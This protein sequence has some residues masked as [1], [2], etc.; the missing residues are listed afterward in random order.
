MLNDRSLIN[1]GLALCGG[2]TV[3]SGL[4][5]L[6][7]YESDLIKG[8][9]EVASLFLAAFA[10]LHLRL[11]WRAFG[12]TLGSAPGIRLIMIILAA[13]TSA[14]LVSGSFYGGKTLETLLQQCKPCLSEEQKRLWFDEE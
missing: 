13:A 1:R 4:M 12:K 9:H 7:H 11:N 3:I 8:T 5:L 10:I 6:F 14:M 2:L